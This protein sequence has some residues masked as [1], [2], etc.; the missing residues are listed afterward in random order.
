MIPNKKH[1][2]SRSSGLHF[3][4]LL[5]IFMLLTCASA[6]IH[7]AHAA[8]CIKGLPCVVPL[9]PNDPDIDTDGPN[10]PPAPNAHWNEPLPNK[11]CDA[12]LLNQ[13]HARAF[14]EAE[15][16]MVT[17]NAIILK[18]DSVLEYTCLD[19]EIARAAKVT[20]PLFSE[21]DLWH[22]TTV[23]IG[24][25]I[26]GTPVPNVTIDVYTSDTYLDE[27]LEPLVMPAIK[28]Y[29]D[30]NFWH[31]F[32]GGA[33]SGDDNNIANTV[34]GVSSTC[35]FMYNV[36]FISKCSDF[37][38]EAPF[39]TFEE[40]LTTDPRTLP[41][42][43]GSTHQITKA[44]IDVSKNKDDLY[45]PIEP[46]NLFLPKI[47]PPGGSISCADPIPTGVIVKH[48]ER[49]QDLAGNPVLVKD[50]SFPEQV[51]P[52]PAC[53]LDNKNNAS[54]GDDKCVQ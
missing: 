35:D 42:A 47:L 25:H 40:L 36:F 22:P 2:L 6:A 11:F 39:M 52:N 31:D 1:K 14:L 20:G 29:V 7:P 24:G 34:M 41:D 44:L 10:I 30:D 5:A 51:C 26:N 54:P 33:A 16:A 17:A 50:Y 32:L 4:G 46:V 48:V 38:L 3:S 49:K 45:A 28:Q 23:P 27:I 18:P 21:S 19:Q 43:C 37:A 9:T 8:A 15:R 12:D 13:M 53:H